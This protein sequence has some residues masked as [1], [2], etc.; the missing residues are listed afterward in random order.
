MVFFDKNKKLFKRWRCDPFQQTK[1]R[2]GSK[3]KVV[4]VFR[5]MN[6]KGPDDPPNPPVKAMEY[7]IAGCHSELL[8]VGFFS[9]F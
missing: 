2:F 6:L 9:D 7:Q 8:F 4:T 5:T 3:K 1:T